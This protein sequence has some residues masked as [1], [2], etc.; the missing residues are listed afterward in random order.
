MAAEWSWKE[1]A[2]RF[3]SSA[4][5]DPAWLHN[6]TAISEICR[7]ISDSQYGKIFKVEEVDLHSVLLRRRDGSYPSKSLKIQAIAGNR[8][9]FCLSDSETHA[10][11]YYPDIDHSEA[12][13]RFKK[14]IGTIDWTKPVEQERPWW[15]RLRSLLFG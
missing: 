4:G 3:S 13:I 5:D 6:H 10:F 7:L 11:R 2:D 8:V 14:A 9:E 1:V 15:D 12:S